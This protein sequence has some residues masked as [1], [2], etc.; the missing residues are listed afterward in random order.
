MGTEVA[1]TQKKLAEPKE[2][3]ATAIEKA[4]KTIREG[5]VTLD[6]NEKE[7]TRFVDSVTFVDPQNKSERYRIETI[8]AGSERRI[9]PKEYKRTPDGFRI[10]KC[11]SISV[12]R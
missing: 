5:I 6:K 9:D 11:D 7:V 1:T 10:Y 12:L 8:P 4:K 2:T 3:M